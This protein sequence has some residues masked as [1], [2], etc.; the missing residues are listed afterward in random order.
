MRVLLT[1]CGSRGD[2]EPLVA[3]GVRLRELG[4]EVLMCAP[5]LAAERLAEVD[6]PLVPIGRAMRMMLRRRPTPEEERRMAYEAVA[7]QFDQVPPAA[8]GCDAVVTTGEL[9]AAVAVRS[10]AERLGIPYFY[11]T[12]APV[13]LPSPHHPPPLDER[14][15]P[16]VTDNRV[17]WEQRAQRFRDRFAGP[18]N[19][20]RAAIGLPPVADIFGYGHTDRPWMAADPVLAPLR[21]GQDAVQTGAWILPDDRPLSAELEAF[22][23]AGPPA[24]YVGFGSQS[25]TD[26]AATVAIEAIRARGL[27]VILSRGWAD[28]AAPDDGADCLVVEE[29]NLQVL[30]GR[31]AAVVHHGSAG[32]TTVATRAGSPQIVIP[33]DTDQPYFAER[34][35]ALG[36][37]VAHDGPD[38]TRESLSAALTTALAPG[39]RARA[40]AVAATIRDDAAATVARQLLDT[41]SRERPAAAV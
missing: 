9:S 21:P 38:P 34:V 24:V 11:A 23:A 41:V 4:A 30:F 17:L 37:G 33:R 2:V 18:V 27:R 1:T 13:Y 19:D 10:V 32:T 29:T 28:L 6:V 36:A 25:G 8:E 20:R 16:G 22:L 39:T 14:R 3:L 5:P 35:A 15:T 40:A 26:D 7:M 31:V 12:H